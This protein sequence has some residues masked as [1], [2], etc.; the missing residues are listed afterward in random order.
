MGTLQT[1]TGQDF[2]GSYPY[3]AV[4]ADLYYA[5]QDVTVM[6]LA[7]ILSLPVDVV[8]DTGFLPVDLAAWACGYEKD[9]YE[10]FD[11]HLSP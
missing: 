11:F 8:V 4:V 3:K 1:R 5:P 10:N 2:F 6:C 9:S 7:G